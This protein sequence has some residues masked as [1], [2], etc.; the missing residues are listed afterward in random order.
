M[1]F[2]INS[3]THIIF[4][5]LGFDYHSLKNLISFLF[6]I[7]LVYIALTGLPKLIADLFTDFIRPIPKKIK[8]KIKIKCS[9]L[10]GKFEFILG[11]VGVIF[12][13]YNIFPA[14][15]G[16]AESLIINIISTIII[17]LITHNIFSNLTALFTVLFLILFMTVSINLFE[18]GSTKED[19]IKAVLVFPFALGLS[20][21]LSLKFEKLTNYI[22]RIKMI[23]KNQ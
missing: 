6:M 8:E 16:S 23:E 18:I 5:N 4:L 20:L 10:K 1:A 3:N 22:F 21:F 12:V 2:I 7:L 9:T 19:L 15:F 11:I 17:I 14:I 13:S